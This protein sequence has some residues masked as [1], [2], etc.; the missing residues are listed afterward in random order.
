MYG[1][2]HDRQIYTIN[3]TAATGGMVTGGGEYEKGNEVTLTATPDKNYLFNGWYEN[4]VKISGIGATY[5][6]TA[7]NDRYLVAKFDY[8]EGGGNIQPDPG[9]GAKSPSLGG[10]GGGITPPASSPTPTPQPTTTPPTATQPT[11][12]P[13]KTTLSNTT[14]PKIRPPLGGI[15]FTLSHA[16]GNWVNPYS[17]VQDTDWFFDAL[18]FVTV[19]NLMAGTGSGNF[20]PDITMSRAMLVTVLYRLEGNPIVTVNNPFTDVNNDEWYSDA[21]LWASENNI[22]NGYDNGVFGPDDPVSR[23]QAI[24]ILYRFAQYNGLDI[25]G[26]ADLSVYTDENDISDWAYKAMK[27]AVSDEIIKGR[28]PTTIVPQG[29]S[30]R[31]EVATVINRFIEK[32]F[33]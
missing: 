33:A 1:D 27:W 28:T 11:V 13:T 30:T 19:N 9:G 21:I 14:I 10:G 7:N 15:S 20:S 29:T 25:S 12:K 18:G 26:S 3:A 24:A 4:N 6:F 22:V 31:A 8:N 32:C 5:T 23:E 16:A 17:D 2:L